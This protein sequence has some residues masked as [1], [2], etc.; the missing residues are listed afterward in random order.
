SR[1]RSRR[2]DDLDGPHPFE[3]GERG[4]QRPVRDA[5]DVAEGLAEPLLQLVAVEGGLRQQAQDRK[6][7]HGHIYRLDISMPRYRKRAGS[8]TFETAGKRTG[9]RFAPACTSV[10]SIR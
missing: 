5:P 6:F 2:V 9:P 1:R 10:H 3:A 4:I 8:Q 7:K